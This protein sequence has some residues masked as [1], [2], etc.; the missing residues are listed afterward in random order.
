QSGRGVYF[1]GRGPA[2][3]VNRLQGFVKIALEDQNLTLVND[4]GIADFTL[5]ADIEEQRTQGNFYYYV[6]K[7]DSA[8]P[9][10][11]PRSLEWST[12][13]TRAGDAHYDLAKDAL[14][15]VPNTVSSD[16]AGTSTVF[17]GNVNSDVGP[18]SAER[19]K[20]EF[21]KARFKIVDDPH[22]AEVLLKDVQLHTC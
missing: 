22:V 15:G 13:T 3:L 2:P 14:S 8:G 21:E 16:F 7:I 19:L 1:I 11:N 18:D 12:S 9:D 10:R 5:E 6:Y 4:Q 20:K 17:V